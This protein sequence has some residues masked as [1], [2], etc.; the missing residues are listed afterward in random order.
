MLIKL[1]FI[2]D[3]SSASLG[4]EE[5]LTSFSASISSE[6]ISV[7]WSWDEADIISLTTDISSLLKSITSSG[8]FITLATRRSLKNWTSS[9]VKD[10]ISAP[11]SEREFMISRIS[12]LFPL[13]IASEIFESLSRSAIPSRL[14]I[15]SSVISEENAES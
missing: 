12:A 5:F 4:D 9:L 13:I 8:F 7:S 6:R 14:L 3:I 11:C 15:S 10:L 2:R 1:D